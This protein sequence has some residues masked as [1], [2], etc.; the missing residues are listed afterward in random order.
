MWVHDIYTSTLGTSGVQGTQPWQ[1]LVL[2]GTPCRTQTDP[3]LTQDIASETSLHALARNF[4]H[5]LS[6]GSAANP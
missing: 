1:T 4:K 6:Q 5:S 3:P 2:D